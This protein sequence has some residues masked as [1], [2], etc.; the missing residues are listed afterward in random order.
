MTG[1]TTAAPG[2]RELLDRDAIQATMFRFGRALDTRDWPLYRAC[3]TD[4]VRIDFS[5]LTGAPA[6][7][8]AA[9]DWTRFAA[10]CLDP[11]RA[12]HQTTNMQVDIEGDHAT[13]V[14]YMAARHHRP[15]SRGDSGYLQLGWYDA[16]LIRDDAAWRV[17]KLRQRIQWCEGNPALIDVTRPE[18]A[19]PLHAV[20]GGGGDP[21]PLPDPRPLSRKASVMAQDQLRELS[22]RAAIDQ[23]MLRFGRALDLHD[24]PMYRSTFL[25]RIEVDFRD[26]TGQP[27]AVV[28]ADLWTEFARLLLSPLKVHHQYSNH[29]IALDGDAATSVLYHASR[30]HRAGDRGS[31]ENVQYGWYENSYVRT[32]HGWRIARLKHCFQWVEGNDRLLEANDP[33]LNEVSRRLFSP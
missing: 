33:E 2:L 13:G 25:D 27:P 16:D 20:F 9:D 8:V 28:D 24:W 5:D 26:L 14:F 21:R 6:R 31:S 7:T 12:H 11:I 3:L 4:P 17:R 32:D 15:G 10:A 18:I 29:V 1:V 22:E 19:G 30:H 23:L